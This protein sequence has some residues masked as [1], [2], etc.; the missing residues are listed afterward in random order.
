M[1]MALIGEQD[2]VFPFKAFG[3]EVFPA[4]NSEEGERIIRELLKKGGYAFLFVSETIY[5]G[6]SK[7]IS[8]VRKM[9]SPGIIPVPSVK[10]RTNVSMENLRE[11]IR[12][13]IGIDIGG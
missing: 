1:N 8:E 3:I 7:I 9:P 4:N 12:K 11:I 6:L 10:G 5:S 2:M 13:A